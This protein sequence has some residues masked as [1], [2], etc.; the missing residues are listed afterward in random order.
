MGI[1]DETDT[2]NESVTLKWTREAVQDWFDEH[3]DEYEK[4]SDFDRDAPGAYSAAVRYGMIKY[5][6]PKWRK[7]PKPYTKPQIKQ[8]LKRH[9]EITSP[10]ELQKKNS[11]AYRRAWESGWIDELFPHKKK[12]GPDMM[13]PER[14]AKRRY[15]DEQRT[16]YNAEREQMRQDEETDKKLDK[17]WFPDE[18]PVRI[19]EDDWKSFIRR[20]N[21]SGIDD[22][23]QTAYRKTIDEYGELDDYVTAKA[24]ESYNAHYARYGSFNNFL[25]TNRR[26]FEHGW[27]IKLKDNIRFY[28]E[29]KRTKTISL[30]DYITLRYI[31]IQT[32]IRHQTKIFGIYPD[33][34]EFTDY[35]IDNEEF[36]RQYR[37]FLVFNKPIDTNIWTSSQFLQ[38]WVLKQYKLLTVDDDDN[39]PKYK[40]WQQNVHNLRLKYG[41]AKDDD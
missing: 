27:Y 26:R 18:L 19:F 9:P 16:R 36:Q 22:P 14:K 6:F 4:P 12:R 17:L 38:M 7:K 29:E 39:N 33:E 21:T 25:D 34:L 35:V 30:K 3:G 32:F 31:D 40:Y 8:Y 13:T 41:Y 15:D 20:Y 24:K 2:M 10:N 37:K 23:K 28:E 5:L 11:R 1:N